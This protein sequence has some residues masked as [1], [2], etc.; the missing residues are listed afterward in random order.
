[1]KPNNEF[2]M[3]FKDRYKTYHVFDIDS[4]KT[5]CGRHITNNSGELYVKNVQHSYLVSVNCKQCLRQVQ[6]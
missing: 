6:K 4:K 2:V 5:L 3:K 1:M